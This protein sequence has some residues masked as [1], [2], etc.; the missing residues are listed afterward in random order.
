MDEP[1]EYFAASV[2]SDCGATSRRDDYLRMVMEALSANGY[3]V[4]RYGKC[5]NRE[6]PGTNL[7]QALK[8]LAKYKL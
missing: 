2:I 6:L 5:G 7:Q 4:H 3:R 1:K 8:F